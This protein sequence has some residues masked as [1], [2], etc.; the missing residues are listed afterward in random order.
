VDG[1]F[2][3]TVVLAVAAVA[4]VVV[5]IFA[6]STS[7]NSQRDA[8]RASVRPLIVEGIEGP[9][10]PAPDDNFLELAIRNLGPGMA[11]VCDVNVGLTRIRG[12][13]WDAIGRSPSPLIE[14]RDCGFDS[15]RCGESMAAA[16]CSLEA[17]L[18]EG[19]EGTA[20]TGSWR[21]LWRGWLAT[22]RSSTSAVEWETADELRKVMRPISTV[23]DVLSGLSLSD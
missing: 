8:L 20:A 22:A 13:S 17:L 1:S 21:R 16:T 19:I 5:S 14:L 6:A 10:R 3:A 12:I 11:A 7:L 18:S 9:A 4:R 2:V 15:A 23:F